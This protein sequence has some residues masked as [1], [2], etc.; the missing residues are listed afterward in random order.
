MD[1]HESGAE[2]LERDPPSIPIKVEGTSVSHPNSIWAYFV[3]SQTSLYA[4]KLLAIKTIKSGYIT[5]DDVLSAYVWQGVT[6][7]RLSRLDSVTAESTFN[8][9]VDVRK[10]RGISP[11]Y[12]GNAVS[13]TSNTLT[14]RYIIEEPLG[15]IA[16]YLRSSLGSIPDISYKTR[17]ATTILTKKAGANKL[18]QLLAQE[19][20]PQISR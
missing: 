10:L 16:S 11:T 15:V 3:F 18:P 12:V 4:L 2:T 13:T 9:L 7:T 5:T 20:R 14:A 1:E 6:H 17:A 8:R 19:Y